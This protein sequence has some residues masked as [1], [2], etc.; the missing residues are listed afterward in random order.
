ME[1]PGW[2]CAQIGSREL[3]AVPRCLEARGKLCRL[4]TD[5]WCG[6]SLIRAVA[7][8]FMVPASNVSR[9]YHPD[10][11]PAKVHAF[12][13]WSLSEGLRQAVSSRRLRTMEEATRYNLRIGQAFGTRV[14]SH[15]EPLGLDP[16]KNFIFAFSTGA[17]E[18]L[19][20]AKSK[21]IIAVLDQL[22]PAMHDHRAVA[23]EMAR[24]PGWAKTPGKPAAEYIDRHRAEWRAAPVILVNSGWSKDA[25]VADGV[26]AGKIIVVP[27]AYEPEPGVVPIIHSNTNRPLHV[28]W[29][30]QIVLRKGIPYLFDAARC[31]PGVKF[32][33]AGSIGVS[34]MALKSAPSNV[35]IL[36][37]V[38]RAEAHRLFRE[39]D[40]FVLPTMSDGFAL[41]QLEAMAHGLPVIA[42]P[43]CGE[44]VTE[45]RDGFIVPAGDADALAAAVARVD[46]NRSLLPELSRCAA[47]KSAEFTLDRY[48]QALEDAVRR[49]LDAPAASLP[50][51]ERRASAVAIATAPSIRVA[52]LVAGDEILGVAQAVRGLAGAVRPLGIE[53]M[54]IA[55]TDG[56]FV[57]S[58]RSLGFAVGVLNV[59]PLP[60]LRG[61]LL[62]KMKLYLRSRGTVAAI[63]P[64][65]A[66]SLREVGAQAVHV[67]WP[68]LMPLAAMAAHDA[69][70]ACIW[71]M[72][73]VMGKY[74]LGI[75][76]RILQHTL[77]RWN[78]MPMANSRYT[79]ATL[80]D[81]PVKPTILH[82]GADAQRFDPDRKDF[83]DRE[84]L[85]IP[86]DAIVLGIFG[87]IRPAKG[88]GL[89]LQTMAQLPTAYS[90]VHLLL[91]GGPAE[92]GF[93][94]E[95]R[96]V[97]GRMGVVERLHLNGNVPDPERYYGAVD[98]VIS[99]YAG[100]ESFGLSVVEAM[101][102]GK[103]V[104]VHALGGPAETVL[105]G[106][107]GWHVHEP[108]VEG[109]KAGLLRALGEREKWAAL[110]AAGR[111]RALEYFNLSRQAKQYVE[112]VRTRLGVEPQ[113]TQRT[114]R[115][116]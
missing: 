64:K 35:H 83:I 98:L 91:L 12:N 113:S 25:L 101:M 49:H 51:Q 76:H 69:G 31:L 26:P 56:P 15:L 84:R 70:I 13:A 74:P 100:A 77:R 93:A 50:S 92:G 63:R 103:P 62:S 114:Q 52:W 112:I 41:T 99:A 55:L 9:R 60:T 67:L 89:I 47:V 81:H 44:V 24:W 11:P 79:A 32:S 73:N 39:S 20:L 105:D 107:T 54:I 22:D 65:L 16:D 75:N 78:V 95:L 10:I 102:M 66:D 5:S 38:G 27:L 18:I 1:Q 109:F 28:L 45:G 61:G 6:S 30:G 46:Q 23:E 53:P 7:K 19:Q 82:L 110:G 21:G 3:Y 72:P 34:D 40:I 36:G 29:L 59:D 37:K 8:R 115:D 94:N 106:V 88:Q 90:N 87:R 17:L 43:R 86:A 104:L 68:N 108:T 58:M 71:E 42:T 14:A 57:Q 2:I 96:A 4:Y 33:V 116:I 111:K 85:G 97:A 48:A 80:G